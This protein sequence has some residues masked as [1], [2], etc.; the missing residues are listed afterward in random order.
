MYG[1]GEGLWLKVGPTGRKKWLFRFQLRGHR[2]DM[3]L[4]SVDDI[5]LRDA[6]LARNEAKK[7]IAQG[8]NPLRARAK[9]ENAPPEGP[10]FAAPSKTFNDAA[11]EYLSAH[12]ITWKN[13]KHRQQ[14][15][16]TLATYVRQR[17]GTVP[18]DQVTTDD[19]LSILTPIWLSKPE[20]ARRVRGRI[21]TI[22]DYAC[23]RGWRSG[24]NPARMKGHLDHLLPGRPSTSQ[25]HHAA[26]PWR[27]LPG[28]F[29]SLS[30]EGTSMS[31]LALQFCILTACRTSEVLEATWDEVNMKVGIW[32]IPPARMK[33]GRLHRVPLSKQALEL[34][35]VLKEYRR[36]QYIF[37]GQRDSR[38]L[39]NM[40]M[41]MM[42]RRLGYGHFTVHGFRS[43]FRD[44]AA[45]AT[46]HSNSVAEMALAHS[47]KDKVEAAYR[48]GD[49][50][51]KRV[52]LMQDWADY[53]NDCTPSTEQVSELV[54]RLSREDLDR[55]LALV[56]SS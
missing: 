21:E 44:W 4:G 26:M 43:S 25:S 17:I 49:M 16:N 48:R 8:I 5:S 12:M 46:Q 39:S 37:P 34:L 41:L 2:Q 53:L 38:P 10:S 19:V 31:S 45:E 50:L 29:M 23:A 33:M 27:E 1:D 3:W 40:S 47:I 13:A 24:A 54:K 14:W 9:A 6:R 18:V 36:D 20:T 15:V 42:M 28:F 22:L 56:R 55:L 52:A 7:L 51:E 35:E 30:G 32:S 11:N